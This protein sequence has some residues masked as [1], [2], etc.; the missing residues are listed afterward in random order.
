LPVPRLRWLAF[1]NV[2]SVSTHYIRFSVPKKSGGLRELAKPHQELDR[3]QR[4]ILENI[5]KK[6]PVHPAAHGF[7]AGRSTLTG[8]TPHV[9]QDVVINCDLEEFFPSI[10]VYRVIGFFKGL[11]YSPAIATILA[12]LVTEC[13]RRTVMLAGTRYHVATGSRS[14]PQGACTSPAISNL[15]SWKLDKRLAGL[16]AKFSGN[17]TRYADDI[18]ISGSGEMTE[19]VGWLLAK[20]RHIAQEEGF[21]SNE[22]KTRVQRRNTAQSVTGIVVNDRPGVPRKLMRRLRAI[23]HRAQFEGLENQNRENHPNFTAWVE[24]MVA[25]VEMVNPKQGERLRE[26]L[27]KLA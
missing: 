25:Y 4:W 13:P 11:G 3:C 19:K 20:I 24:G 5:L 10:T 22:K 6:I 17:Y 2:A 12:L 1:H 18:T 23:L 16:A 15:I 27:Q 21:R 9:N 8:A 14:L 7:V 26:A